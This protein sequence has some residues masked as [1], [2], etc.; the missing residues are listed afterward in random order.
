[1]PYGLFALKV[2]NNLEIP[3]TRTRIHFSSSYLNTFNNR[4]SPL[5]INI[6]SIQSTL[7]RDLKYIY[8]DCT[9]EGIDCKLMTSI[10]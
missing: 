2:V 1:M 9:E 3:F 5:A 4:I 10:L 6:F 8:T 7:E